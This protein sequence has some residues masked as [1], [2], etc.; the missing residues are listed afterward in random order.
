[1]AM[2]VNAVAVV[3]G[4][5]QLHLLERIT[6]VSDSGNHGCLYFLSNAPL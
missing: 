2:Y 3:T 5:I 4:H 1:M 6:S